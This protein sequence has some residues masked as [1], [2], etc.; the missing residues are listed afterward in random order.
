MIIIPIGVDCGLA[1]LLNKYGLRYC[2]FPFDWN[3]TYNGV[4]SCFND[5]FKDFIPE[6]NRSNKYDIYF[7]HDFLTSSFEADIIK[8]HR[9]INRM[10]NIL[11]ESR[12]EICFCRRG[13]S[14]DHHLEHDNI[15]CE[16]ANAEHL[17]SV[18]KT[19]YGTL[20]YKIH[21]MLVCTKCYDAAKTYETTSENVVI[22]NIVSEP[23]GVIFEHAFESRARQI[24]NV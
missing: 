18:L 6:S 23:R 20:K 24:F 8:Y 3:M 9:R 22:H 10:V 17:D 11:E 2:S 13:H 1:T 14:C 19:K 5:N 15:S 7:N 4:S 12:E 21:V 16:I